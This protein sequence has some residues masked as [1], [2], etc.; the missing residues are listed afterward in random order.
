MKQLQR[1]NFHPTS[2]QT[3]PRVD[4]ATCNLDHNFCCI[5][6]MRLGKVCWVIEECG[7][8]RIFIPVLQ[9][10]K[11]II[12]SVSAFSCSQAGCSSQPSYNSS[13][14]FFFFKRIINQNKP[15]YSLIHLIPWQSFSGSS[16]SCMYVVQNKIL[17][18]ASPDKKD[19]YLCVCVC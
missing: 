5:I 1:W 16:L 6:V 18:L 19:Q 13:A 15:I 9:T 4:E 17:Q 3:M 2:S 7:Q 11:T 12:L 8:T 10:T 14:S